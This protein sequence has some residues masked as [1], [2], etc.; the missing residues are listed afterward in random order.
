[1]YIYH[2]LF[3][4][5]SFDGHLDCFHILAIVN[6]IVMNIGVHISFLI[7]ALLSSLAMG[8]QNRRSASECQFASQLSLIPTTFSIFSVIE[9]WEMPLQQFCI[10]SIPNLKICQF[11]YILSGF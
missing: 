9:R 4:Y 10:G 5:S 1:M 11:S 6:S 7:S 2:T 3:I 8:F